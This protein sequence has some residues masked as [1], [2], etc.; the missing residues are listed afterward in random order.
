MGGTQIKKIY[1]EMR[2]RTSRGKERKGNEMK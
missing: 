1:A 2:K